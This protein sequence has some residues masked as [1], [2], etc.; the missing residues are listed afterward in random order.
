LLQYHCPQ[1]WEV[2]Q[3]SDSPREVQLLA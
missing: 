1:N 2:G 3:K